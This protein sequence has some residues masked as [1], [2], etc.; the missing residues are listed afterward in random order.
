M[1]TEK[2]RRELSLR[3]PTCTCATFEFEYGIDETIQIAKC[4]SCSRTLTKDD[5]VRE[6]SEL[7]QVQ[8][9]EFSQEILKDAAAEMRKVLKKALRGNKNIRFK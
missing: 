3:C 4:A 5:L 2:Y 9:S 7:I 6:N 8:S 1:D